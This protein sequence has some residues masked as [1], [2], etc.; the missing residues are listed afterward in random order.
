MHDQK[1]TLILGKVLCHKK[2]EGCKEVSVWKVVSTPDL[3]SGV[4][5][6]LIMKSQVGILLEAEFN[7]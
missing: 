1:W 2:R 4:L 5:L 7:S 6:I 3:K